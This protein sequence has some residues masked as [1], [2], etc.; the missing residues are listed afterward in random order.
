MDCRLRICSTVLSSSFERWLPSMLDER[1]TLTRLTVPN[2]PDLLVQALYYVGMAFG[3]DADRL[4]RRRRVAPNVIV[5]IRLRN[6]GPEGRETHGLE[7]LMACVDIR[8]AHLDVQTLQPDDL[9]QVHPVPVDRDGAQ[10]SGER[11]LGR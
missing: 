7:A 9:L 10:L 1:R 2:R 6:D 4:F 8:I 5:Q 11:A 3:F